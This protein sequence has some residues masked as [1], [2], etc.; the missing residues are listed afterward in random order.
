MAVVPK[1]IDIVVQQIGNSL[2]RLRGSNEI[3]ED[4]S[5]VGFFVLAHGRHFR[6]K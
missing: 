6:Q 4:M 5:G 2:C 3:L 1:L